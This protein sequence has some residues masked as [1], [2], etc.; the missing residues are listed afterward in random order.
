MYN[1]DDSGNGGR[2]YRNGGKYRFRTT[3]IGGFQVKP[4]YLY[5][6][7]G[8][9]FLLVLYLLTRLLNTSLVMHFGLLAGVLLLLANGR[10]LIGQSYGQPKSTAMLNVLIGGSLLFAWLSQIIS[11]VMWAPAVGLL[12]V[13]APLAFGRASV[14][15]TYMQTARGAMQ[16]IRQ[17]VS[18]WSS[19]SR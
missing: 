8:I 5:I 18:R 10:E 19:I 12:V 13:A 15:R 16:N 2:G 7:A 4:L 14:Y 1:G 17:I 6:A 3:T 11:S 9:A